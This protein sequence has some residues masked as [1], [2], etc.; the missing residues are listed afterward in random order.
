MKSS[1]AFTQHVKNYIFLQSQLAF[2][3]LNLKMSSGLPRTISIFTGYQISLDISIVNEAF[4]AD[5]KW[6]FTFIQ[7]TKTLPFQKSFM[8]SGLRNLARTFNKKGVK[9]NQVFLVFHQTGCQYKYAANDGLVNQI[10]TPV[11]SPMKKLC[12]FLQYTKVSFFKSHSRRISELRKPM[13]A[14][15]QWSQSVQP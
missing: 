9:I 11:F 2:I 5:V 8:V 1:F 6:F 14:L 12:A 15:L 3:W 10:L 13:E 7:Y 4:F